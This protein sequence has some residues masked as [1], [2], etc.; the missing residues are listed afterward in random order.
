MIKIIISFLC[1]LISF[2]V[3]WIFTPWLIKYLKRI[4]LVDFDQN[5]ENKPLFPTSGGIIVMGGMFIG[6][7][8]YVFFKVFFFDLEIGKDYLTY[9]FA[10]ITSILIITFVGF[11]DDLLIKRNHDSGSGLKQWQKPL[12]VLPAA[13][14]L[15][16]INAGTSIMSIPLFGDVNFG[17]IYPLVLIPMGVFGAANMVNLLAGFN[18]ME[19]GMGIVYTGMLGLYAY[20]NGRLISALIALMAFSALLAFYYYNKYPTKIFPGDSLTY[21]LGATLACIAILGNME[22][23]CLIVAIPFFIEFV[24]KARGKFQKQSY[25]Y[26][27]DGKIHNLYGKEIYSIPHLLTRTGKYTEKQ[28]TYFCIFMEFIFASL[29]WLI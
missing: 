15:M 1:A 5:K 23:A 17:L 24:L 20:M 8:M 28:V 2:L 9:V 7:L 26:Y 27:K 11:I 4:N 29:I 10:A 14:P 25:G 22:K 6:L 12:L 19:A 13:I 18:G 21:L 3:I 16:V